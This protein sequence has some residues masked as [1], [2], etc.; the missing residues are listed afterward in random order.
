M[1][2]FSNATEDKLRRV[3]ITWSQTTSETASNMKAVLMLTIGV[4]VCPAFLEG[5]GYKHR[6][7]I[8]LNALPQ[9]VR[10]QFVYWL[11]EHPCL[12]Q[13]FYFLRI[14][15]FYSLPQFIIYIKI[16]GWDFG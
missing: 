5:F 9:V 13:S 6:C 12:K 14:H 4:N 3:H 2:I 15:H 10:A 8:L 1:Q 16:L 7:G 11:K